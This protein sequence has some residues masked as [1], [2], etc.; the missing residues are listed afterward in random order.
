MPIPPVPTGPIKNRLA[1]ASVILG[2]LS[3]CLGIFTGIPAIICGSM[4]LSRISRQPQLYA[5]KGI[6]VVGI[7]LGCVGI[8]IWAVAVAAYPS[9][10]KFN[11]KIATAKQNA[12]MDNCA[13]KL[14]NL[15]LAAR[16]YAV[17]HAKQFPQSYL[18]IKDEIGSP[19][20]LFCRSDTQHQAVESWND[21][22]P[23]ESSYELLVPGARESDTLRKPVF[24][25]KIH[26]F[27][28]VG[29]GSV[30]RGRRP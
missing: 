22:K 13:A 28:V 5:G 2:S 25:C 15:G 17:D 16:I 1:L 8:L 23:S 6:A 24:R 11:Q 19:K 12:E 7:I 9:L 14:N 29:D 3:L 26:G 21:F 10:I 4:G 20:I 18:D 27:Y 30:I